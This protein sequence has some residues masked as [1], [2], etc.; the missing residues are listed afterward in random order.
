MFVYIVNK[1]CFIG[2]D[3]MPLITASEEDAR[4]GVKGKVRTVKVQVDDADLL[5]FITGG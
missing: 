4:A 2:K 1:L 5:N 3:V